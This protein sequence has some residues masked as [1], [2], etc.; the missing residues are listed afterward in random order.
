MCRDRNVFGSYRPDEM[1]RV[2][3]RILLVRIDPG[4]ESSSLVLSS[5]KQK[6]LLYLQLR[7]SAGCRFSIMPRP[8]RLGLIP[9]L[10]FFLFHLSIYLCIYFYIF[11]PVSQY[12]TE[13]MGAAEGTKM[14]D[15]FVE[16][17]RV[18]VV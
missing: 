6:C 10:F 11:L 17:E 14:D 15:D 4:V 16:M 2:G 12:V 1:L 7:S 9:F 13:K 18:S 8:S 3:K 5:T